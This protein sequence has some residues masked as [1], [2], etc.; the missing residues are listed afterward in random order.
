[1][2]VLLDQIKKRPRHTGQ[3]KFPD[4]QGKKRRKQPLHSDDGNKG[5]IYIYWA[6]TG[7]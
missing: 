5:V 4:S 1:M 2:W 6:L 3:I 7:A